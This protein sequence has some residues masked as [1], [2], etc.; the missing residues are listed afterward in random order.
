MP[1]YLSPGT[2]YLEVKATGLTAYSL[3]SGNL[4]LARPAW[5]MPQP[6]HPVAAPGLDPAGPLFGDTGVSASG[7]PLPSDQGVDL[8]QDSFH[9]YALTVSP[10]NPGLLRTELIAIS[11]NP[12]LYLRTNAP[13]TL[14]HNAPGSGSPLYSRAL[15][16]AVGT[17]YGNWAVLNGKNEFEL[18]PGTWFL[19]VHAAGGSTVR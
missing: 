7:T 6:G 3:V 1:D 4:E 2:W 9:Y 17:E 18:T 5:V 11:G 12:N 13:P 15:T 19:A 10:G 16:N 8:E 14:S